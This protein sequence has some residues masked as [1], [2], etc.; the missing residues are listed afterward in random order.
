MT[1]TWIKKIKNSRPEESKKTDMKTK[2]FS[3]GISE[4]RKM[5]S[6]KKIKNLESRIN[7]KIE[8]SDF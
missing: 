1:N 4:T 3:S 6:K 5:P 7:K 8:R 2:T